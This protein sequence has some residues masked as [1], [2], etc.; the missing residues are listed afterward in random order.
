MVFWTIPSNA[1]TAREYFKFAKFSFDAK[2]YVKALDYINKSIELE[3]DYANGLMLRVEIYRELKNYHAI[4]PDANR[5]IKFDNQSISLLSQAH[6]L[7]GIAFYFTGNYQ[8]ASDDFS[9]SLSLNSGIAEAY[10]YQG[11]IAYQQSSHFQA[12]ELF[13][14]AIQKEGNNFEYFF[15]RAKLKIEYFHPLPNTPAFDHIMVDI[16][17]SIDL[18]PEDPRA[19]KLKCDMLKRNMTAARD[20]Y[21]DELTKTIELFPDQAEFYAQRGTA[22]ILSNDFVA[23]LADLD[24]AISF[25]GSNE[26]ILRNRA[27]CHHN[28]RNYRL[29]IKDYTTS[30]DLMIA[31]YQQDQDK[32]GKK[33][34][35]ETLVMR[36]RSYEEMTNPDD[37]CTDYYN[38][39]KLGSKIGLNNYRRNCN[40][41]N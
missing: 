29:A 3:P 9:M 22:K 18:N 24:K 16:N 1:E 36:G 7:R 8:K 40:V 6:L 37:A 28:L 25:N 30:I 32:N 35:A 10:F 41:F 20:L 4:I 17:K 13:D 11:L 5:I 26:L 12:L 15:Y 21:I 39:A 14:L 33:V 34:L 31:R 27:L 38:A 23:A 2:D 19:Y